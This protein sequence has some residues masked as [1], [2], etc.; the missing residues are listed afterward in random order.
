MPKTAEI[1]LS[2]VTVADP[3]RVTRESA[4]SLTIT[5]AAEKPV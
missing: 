2:R 1:P 3:N 5:M 4:L